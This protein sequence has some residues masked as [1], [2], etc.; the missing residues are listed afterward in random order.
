M[1]Y[2][3]RRWWIARRIRRRLDG[4]GAVEAHRSSRHDR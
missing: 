4:L 2:W 3:L 1:I